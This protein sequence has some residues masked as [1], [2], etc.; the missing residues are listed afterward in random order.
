MKTISLLLRLSLVALAPLLSH[1]TATATKKP[2]DSSLTTTTTPNKAK[3]KAAGPAA[4]DDLDEYAVVEIAD[5]FEKLN[6]ASFWVND[7][8]YLVFFRPISKGYEKVLPMRVRKGIDNIFEN[9]K[10]P[11]RLVNHTL[12]GDLKNAGL[13]TEKFLLNSVVGLGGIFRVSQKVPVLAAVPDQD[14][15]KTFAKW[16]MGHG[17]YIVI[18]FL[19]P[20]S[21][22]DGIGLIGDY[23]L[24]AANWGYFWNGDH[25]WTMIPPGVNTLRTLPLQL[26]PYDE[27]KRDAL[28]PYI[29]L[30]STYVQ[31]REEWVKK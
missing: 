3:A 1:C 25:D 29:A 20:S 13:E 26:G 28:D 8:L 10:F 31:F 6:R 16:G 4:T 17:A 5:P 18:P 2:V 24:N 12:Q 7:K 23:A 21:T 22:R 15:G 19:G 27:A 9:A 11:V 14:M 30:R